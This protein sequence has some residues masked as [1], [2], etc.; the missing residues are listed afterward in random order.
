M[1]LNTD[2]ADLSS[3]KPSLVSGLGLK[4]MGH[5]TAVLL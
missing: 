2:K 5:T 1:Q 3:N 4:S